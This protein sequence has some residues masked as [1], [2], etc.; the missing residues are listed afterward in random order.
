MAG[1]SNPTTSIDLSRLPAPTMVEQLSYEAI[2]AGMVAKLQELLPSF[3][4]T[5][6]SDPAVK[7]LQVAAYRELLMRQQFNDRALQLMLAYAE[8]SNLEQ[9]A[10]LFGVARLTLDPGDPAAG[11]DPV[12]E[13]DDAL[14]ARTQL[15]P[16]SFTVAGPEPAYIFHTLSADATIRD[17]SATSPVPGQVLITILSS[18]GD[19]TASED[20]LEAVRERLG[21]VSGNKLRPLGDE[22]IVRSAGIVPYTIE[23]ELTL[24]SGPDE[25]LVRA[26][27]DDRVAA[28]LRTSGMLGG[29]ATRFLI[30]RA[31]GVEGIQNVRLI[32]P[33]EDVVV[34]R[35]QSAH[36]V[37]VN[38]RV[39]GLGD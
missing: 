26:A 14:R 18:V 30:N 10:A 11:I 13:T 29:D 25:A 8:G 39:A 4:A 20:Q 36:C 21:V 23:A 9:L 2:L 3:D 1:L 6:D 12:Y 31:I 28:W 19:G 35:T 27:S 38:I 15:A 24:Y 33:P 37:G 34:D 5:V 32:S 17:A 16:E 22:V 7:V